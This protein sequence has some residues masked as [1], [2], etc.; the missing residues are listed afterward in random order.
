[1]YRPKNGLINEAQ[2]NNLDLQCNEEI[3]TYLK[4]LKSIDKSV[5]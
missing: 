5:K 4:Q 2:V 3:R 1:M